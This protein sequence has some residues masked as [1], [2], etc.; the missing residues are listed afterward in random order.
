MRPPA[1]RQITYGAHGPKSRPKPF[2]PRT[3]GV[4]RP[5]KAFKIKILGGWFAGPLRAREQSG[6][7]RNRKR[8]GTQRGYDFAA[9]RHDSTRGGAEQWSSVP[10]RA[11]KCADG[12]RV[13]TESSQ[14]SA[15]HEL[16]NVVEPA[17]ARALVLAAEA[18]RWELVAQIAAELAVRRMRVGSEPR[19]PDSS[20]VWCTG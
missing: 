13:G 20:A 7:A 14:P 15:E 17:L 10:S 9:R 6:G 19:W 8:A 1:A 2:Q 12:G 4:P 11:S 18:Q 5:P 16:R 3:C